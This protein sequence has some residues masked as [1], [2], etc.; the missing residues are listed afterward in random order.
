MVHA[1]GSGSFNREDHQPLKHSTWHKE[2]VDSSFESSHKGRS[3]SRKHRKEKVK[4]HS[5]SKN[6]CHQHHHHYISGGKGAEGNLPLSVKIRLST[7]HWNRP[8][9]EQGQLKEFLIT[10]NG[11]KE[12]RVCHSWQW[13]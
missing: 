6:H 7:S 5:R 11:Q 12:L 8:M 13:Q 10:M 2:D 9:K 1:S 3:W 4:P